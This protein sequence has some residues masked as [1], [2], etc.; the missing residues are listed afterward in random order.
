[1]TY[2]G[3]PIVLKLGFWMSIGWV[4]GAA[5]TV[6]GDASFRQGPWVIWSWLAVPVIGVTLF[7][8]GLWQRDRARGQGARNNTYEIVER[9]RAIKCLVCGMTSWHPQDVTRRYCGE[10]HRFHKELSNREETA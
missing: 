7:S 8:I 2:R 1:M 10:C 6:L 3:W 4:P 5:I 9:G